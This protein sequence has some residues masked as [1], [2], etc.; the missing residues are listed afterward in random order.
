MGYIEFE[1]KAKRTKKDFKISITTSGNF[2]F[3]SRCCLYI[4]KDYKY[5]VFL[6]D[7]DNKR[8]GIKLSKEQREN[9]YS[10]VFSNKANTSGYLGGRAFISMLSSLDI[11]FD[12]K[13]TLIVNWNKEK[14]LIEFDL[15]KECLPAET[16]L[17]R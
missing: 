4:L 8:I 12:R 15:P 7:P 10:I 17:N 9:S 11:K 16:A 14:E 1:N 2:V 5:G 13:T 3:N 6:Y